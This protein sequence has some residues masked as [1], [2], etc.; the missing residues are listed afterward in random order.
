MPAATVSINGTTNAPTLVNWSMVQGED[1]TLSV[2]IDQVGTGFNTAL[3]AYYPDGSILFS[4]TITGFTANVG[5]FTILAANTAG[6][7]PIPYQYQVKRTDSGN[8]TTFSYGAI[9]LIKAPPIP[10]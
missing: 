10:T 1:L 5:N 6:V 3:T 7:D 9:N 2:T 8:V 4:N